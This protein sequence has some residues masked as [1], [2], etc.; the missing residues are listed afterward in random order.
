MK[1]IKKIFG[2]IA[3]VSVIAL[4]FA[5]C[6]LDDGKDPGNDDVQ[7]TLVISGIPLTAVPTG[8]TPATVDIS[9]K[10]IT[11]ALCN[12]KASGAGKGQFELYAWNQV[13]APATGTTGKAEIPLVS[14]TTG[15]QFT[16]TGPY[17]I[18]LWFDYKNTPNDLDDDVTYVYTVTAGGSALPYSIT[19]ATTTIEF[20]KFTITN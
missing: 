8:G 4:S 19:E 17:Y 18:L 3:L 15:V 14:K 10:K 6:D 5:A 2:I 16:G 12:K 20:S 1:N 13:T 7:K 11:A 9:G